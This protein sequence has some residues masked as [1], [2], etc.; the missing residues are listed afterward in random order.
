MVKTKYI[1][2]GVITIVII[3]VVGGLIFLSL[4][5][6]DDEIC[7][8]CGMKNCKMDHS[9]DTIV[10]HSTDNHSENNTKSE[11]MSDININNHDSKNSEDNK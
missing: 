3:A 10:N 8:Y 6:S 5:E 2:I 7:S 11:N 9:N 4:S 1:V